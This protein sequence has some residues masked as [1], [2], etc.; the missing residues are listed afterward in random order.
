MARLPNAPRML[1]A[2]V[3]A[4]G[5]IT[6]PKALRLQLG[7]TAG[8]QILLRAVGEELHGIAA[9]TLLRRLRGVRQGLRRRLAEIE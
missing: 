6:V 2:R 8:S 1:R 9:P 4:K 5:R 7:L 3:D